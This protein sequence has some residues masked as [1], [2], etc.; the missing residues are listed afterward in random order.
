MST[1]AR[2][3]NKEVNAKIRKKLKEAKKSVNTEG[4]NTGQA[5]IAV[6]TAMKDVKLDTPEAKENETSMT[7]PQG[8]KII[9][10][11]IDGVVVDGSQEEGD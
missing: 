1:K 8:K 10:T 5:M 6:L 4:M 11:I 3:T 2:P 9:Y 7:T